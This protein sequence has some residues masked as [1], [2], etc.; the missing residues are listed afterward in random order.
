MSTYLVADASGSL[1]WV[2]RNAGV[3][4]FKAG[5]PDAQGN[6]GPGQV[7]DFAYVIVD[8]A[9]GVSPYTVYLP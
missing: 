4:F 5:P 2:V 1:R 3:G 7:Y 9:T 8:A 6:P